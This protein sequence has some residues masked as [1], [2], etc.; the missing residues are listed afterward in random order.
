MFTTHNDDSSIGPF[1]HRVGTVK[2]SKNDLRELFGEADHMLPK[3][4][5]A[6]MVEFD[7]GVRLT[8]RDHYGK[9]KHVAN[10]KVVEWSVNGRSKKALNKL[11]ELGF[12][13]HHYSGIGV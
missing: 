9:N 7:D 6:W 10:E 1:G 13:T 12:E 4:S 11:E 3:T 5:H 2:A 8:V